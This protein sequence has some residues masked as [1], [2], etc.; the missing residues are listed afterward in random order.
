[1][2]PFLNLLDPTGAAEKGS[3]YREMEDYFYYAQLRSQGEDATKDRQIEDTVEL[4]EVPSIMQAMGH[5]PSVLEIED[6]INE[7]K[8]AKWDDGRGQLQSAIN[9]EDLIKLYV[10]HRPVADY[11][12]SDLE[13]ALSHAPRLAPGNPPPN[14]LMALL[15]QY[16]ET[17]SKEEFEESFRSLLLNEAPY[18]GKLP[19]QA[20][21]REV[22]E[23]ILGLVPSVVPAQEGQV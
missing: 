4:E 19:E 5:Y 14:G 23:D 2:E 13:D 8:Y 9:F 20:S 18:Y 1:M 7:A 12:Q 6:M 21:V 16:G 17:F 3:I 11:T 15:Q 10:N 22:I